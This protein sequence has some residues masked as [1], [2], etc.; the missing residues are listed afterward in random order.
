MQHENLK[1]WAIFHDV[2]LILEGLSCKNSPHLVLHVENPFSPLLV[3]GDSEKTRNTSFWWL[4]IHCYKYW[5]YSFPK[6]FFY[7][8]KHRKYIQQ[9]MSSQVTEIHMYISMELNCSFTLD[10]SLSEKICSNCELDTSYCNSSMPYSANAYPLPKGHW[11]TLKVLRRER[12]VLLTV[13]SFVEIWGKF[14]DLQLCIAML[15]TKTKIERNQVNI[16]YFAAITSC[17]KALPLL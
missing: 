11:R 10:L 12:G 4:I 9:T 2:E 8:Q 13:V 6:T 5:Y 14:V 15:Y 1:F 7:L 16:H 3:D 17:N